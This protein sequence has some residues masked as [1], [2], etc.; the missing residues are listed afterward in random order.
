[1]RYIVFDIET[2]DAVP[3]FNSAEMDLAVVAVYDSGSGEYSSYLEAD[4]PL[5]WPKIESVDMLIG[6]NSNNFDIPLLNKYYPGDL[7][8]IKSLDLLEEVRV[9]LGRR[10]KLQKIAQGTLGKG[11]SGHGLEAVEWWK[12]GEIEKVKKYCIDDVK[13]TKEIYDYALKHGELKYREGNKD[14]PIKID[15]TAWEE[16]ANTSLTHTMPF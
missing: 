16:K 15:T 9:A 2:T 5:L 10:I 6:F 7:T 4:L 1:M 12:K 14:I 3:G 13:I 11:K 8:H